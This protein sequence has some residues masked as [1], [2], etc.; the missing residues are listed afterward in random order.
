MFHHDIYGSGQPH[1]DVDGANLRTIFAPLMDQ[2][3]IDVCLTGHDHSYA[4][5]YQ[6][7]DGKAIDYGNEEAVNPD[8]TLYIAAGSASGSKFYELNAVQQYYIAER[9]NTPTPHI[10][11]H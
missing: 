5:T 8:G 3:D 9:N 7:I 2:Y 11:H 6:I 10:L 1:S 4:R